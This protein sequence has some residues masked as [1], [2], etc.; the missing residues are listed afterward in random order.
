MVSLIY[1]RKLTPIM[2]K[3][4]D[5]LKSEV[6]L[7]MATHSINELNGQ[8]GGWLKEIKGQIHPQ[9]FGRIGFLREEGGERRER[10]REERACLDTQV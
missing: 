8:Q 4:F 3:F 6:F 10:E 5:H 1:L 2:I 7:S 9:Q